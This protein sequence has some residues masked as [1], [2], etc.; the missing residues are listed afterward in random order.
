M[1]YRPWPLVIVAIFHLLAP[2]GNSIQS[3]ILMNV[4]I[5]DYWRAIATQLKPWQFWDFVLTQPLVGLALFMVK[6]WSFPVFILGSGW[7]LYK[8]METHQQF[9]TTF[10]LPMVLGL[11]LVNL[12]VVSYFMIP[13]VRVLFFNRRLRWWEQKPR[14]FFEIK[15]SLT[16][17]SKALA[18][19]IL[20]F[21]EGGVF[22][23][24]DAPL[25]LDQ[26]VRVEFEILDH[27]YSLPAKVVHRQSLGEP[28][29]GIQ[30]FECNKAEK[31]SIKA[32]VR[33]F[34]RM[35]LE[36]RNSRDSLLRD[37]IRWSREL[38]TTG[39]GL[40]PNHGPKKPKKVA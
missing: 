39:K 1:K 29:Y 19:R 34:V 36:N 10:G 27:K 20:N 4:G 9:P 32:L 6:P 15:A 37:L 23:K 33:S 38:I 3:A 24:A 22:F 30:F 21:S 12:G 16:T 17:G 40:V 26:K 31:S 14:Y 28:G 7:N 2:L 11:Y 18:G 5:V 8:V 35:G 25:A 13:Q